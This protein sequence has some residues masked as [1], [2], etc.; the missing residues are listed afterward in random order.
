MNF[1]RPEADGRLAGEGS[2]KTATTTTT[3]IIRTKPLKGL[4]PNSEKT[5]LGHRTR[6]GY[7]P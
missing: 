2:R 7:V 5:G 6:S 1:V 4:A 3:T